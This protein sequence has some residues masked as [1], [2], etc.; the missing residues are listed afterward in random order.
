[1]VSSR[2]R[3]LRGT[4]P[5]TMTKKSKVPSLKVKQ[6]APVE[7]YCWVVEENGLPP[8]KVETLVIS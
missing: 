1:M 7:T 3:G 6:T 8:V 2:S 5:L 4:V